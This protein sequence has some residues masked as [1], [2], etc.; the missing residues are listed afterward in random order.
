MIP[1]TSTLGRPQFSLENANSVSASTPRRAHSSITIR[2]GA[3]PALWPACRGR[4]RAAAQR[5]LPSMM[6]ATCRGV[7]L[8]PA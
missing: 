4:P 3:M 8:K 7:A 1:E 6:I 2:A 5:P